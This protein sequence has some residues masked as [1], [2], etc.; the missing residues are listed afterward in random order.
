MDEINQQT[1]VSVRHYAR[2]ESY[3]PVEMSIE[4]AY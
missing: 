4:Q 2:H 3:I 1:R